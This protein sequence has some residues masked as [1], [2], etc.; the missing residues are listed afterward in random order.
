MAKTEEKDSGDASGN[1]Q[2]SAAPGA[3]RRHHE[4]DRH[5]GNSKE[6]S[7]GRR[8]SAEAHGPSARA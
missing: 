6:T 3:K 2:G 5:D 7:K 1:G 8:L 4:D